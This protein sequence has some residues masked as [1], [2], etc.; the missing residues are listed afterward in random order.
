MLASWSGLGY[1]RR[2][3]RAAGAPRARSAAH[4]WPADLAALPGVGPYTAAAVASFA[5]DAPVAAVDTNVRR[6]LARWDG[7]E[8]RRPRSPRG[9]PSCCPAGRA[10]AFNQA[11]MELGATVCRP[12]GPDCE[13]CP[14]RRGCASA[15]RPR[16]TPA[17]RPGRRERFE[18]SD[19]WAR[20]RIVAAL[21]AGGPG[22]ALEPARRARAERGLERDGLVIRDPRRRAEA[23]VRRVA[24]T[25]RATALD[26]VLDVLLPLL[27]QGVH[28]AAAPAGALELA[29][30]GDMPPLEE[31]AAAIG[32]AL[33]SVA[34]DEAPDD[35]VE[36][37]LRYLEQRPVAGRLVVRPSN[38]KRVE[39][40]MLDV[41]IDS[42][43]G[44][45]G[46]GNHP[47]TEMCLELLLEMEPGGAFADLGCGAGVLAITAALLGY[48]PVLAIDHETSG[49]Q[50]TLRNAAANGVEVDALQA[51]L[52]EV[53]PPPVATLAANVPPAVHEYAAA[54]LPAEVE[55]VI[56]SGVGAGPPGACRRR[57]RRGGPRP[58][59]RAQRRR[60]VRGR[61]GAA[62]MLDP[63]PAAAAG[64]AHGQLASGLP[65]GGLALSGHKF[66]E[67]GA[68][69]LLLLVP[70]L[71]RIDVRP[72]ADTL[73][74]IPRELIDV[75]S[76]WQ[77]EEAAFT[78]YGKTAE[79]TP[80]P[81]VVRFQ[82]LLETAPLPVGGRLLLSY[83]RAREHGPTH[84]VGHAILREMHPEE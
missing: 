78:D 64:V 54:H 10:A 6:V 9:P 24:F 44:A 23:A 80:Q 55:H 33:L 63:G 26:E 48:E 15:G 75:P 40:G 37:R 52:R 5:W 36:R 56:A 7:V 62:L 41:I 84:F 73:Q 72:L 61:A 14:V 35:P 32:P 83:T 34:E 46:S 8:R 39:E 70:G 79:E 12:R 28:R 31:L 47:T 49:L 43:D 27:P 11:M 19:R 68:R 20:G 21:V 22:P 82:L 51:D 38:G 60:L 30:Y 17:P 67:E 2:A 16:A 59:R 53:P 13:A 57:V 77:A 1:N 66:V 81:A 18:D 65:E 69:A 3:L 25:V 50:A 58:R 45:F 71:L 4:G 29:V 42:P 74:V 76:H